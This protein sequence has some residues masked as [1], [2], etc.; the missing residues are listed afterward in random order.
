MVDGVKSKAQFSPKITPALAELGTAQPQL[1]LFYSLLRIT[2]TSTHMP[3]YLFSLT[4]LYVMLITNHWPSLC[5]DLSARNFLMCCYVYC[6]YSVHIY[7]TPDC[8][9]TAV[10]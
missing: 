10:L 4:V 7:S 6:V 9:S 3:I 2:A 5:R 1:V 8:D